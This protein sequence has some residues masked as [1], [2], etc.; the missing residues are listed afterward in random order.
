M[1]AFGTVQNGARYKLTTADTIA[2]TLRP[3]AL[4]HVLKNHAVIR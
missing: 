1:G 3:K 2:S 4:M